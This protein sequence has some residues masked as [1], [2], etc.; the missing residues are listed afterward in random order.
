MVVKVLMSLKKVEL[1][2]VEWFMIQK[3]N[4]ILPLFIPLCDKDIPLGH[5]NESES[6]RYSSNCLLG[7]LW[8][9]GRLPLHGQKAWKKP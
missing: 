2:R 4:E 1:I 7:K 5:S 6:E 3:L 9:V 8:P